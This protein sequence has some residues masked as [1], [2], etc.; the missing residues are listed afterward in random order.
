MRCFCGDIVYEILS[1]DMKSSLYI[2]VLNIFYYSND[3]LFSFHVKHIQNDV[4]VCNI[5]CISIAGLG[6]KLNLFMSV[7]TLNEINF[8]FSHL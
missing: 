8:I 3:I 2:V 6:L 7:E 5:M 1:A 4:R